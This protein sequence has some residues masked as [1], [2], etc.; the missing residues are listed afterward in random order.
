MLGVTAVG[1]TL[2]LWL[3]PSLGGLRFGLAAAILTIILGQLW[4]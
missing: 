3:I 2:S 1:V 4:L